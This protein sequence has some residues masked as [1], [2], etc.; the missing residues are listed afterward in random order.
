MGS[1][2]DAGRHRRR[3]RAVVGA[4]ASLALAAPAGAAGPIVKTTGGLLEGIVVGGITGFRGVPLGE[5]PIGPL[6]WT[7][8]RPARSWTGVRKADSYAAPCMQAKSPLVGGAAPS[9]DCL[10]L[11][12]WTK[13]L[14]PKTPQPVMVVI[15]GGGFTAGSASPP[16]TD[17]AGL[18]KKDV[19]VVALP[20]RVGTL[21]FLAHPELTRESP[22]HASGNYAISDLILGLKWVKANARRFG[23]DPNNVT[24]LGCSAGGYMSSS[25]V[26]SPPAAGL[27][28]R[29]IPESGAAAFSRNAL[30]PGMAGLAQNERIGLA[31]Q[32]QLGARSLAEMRALPAERIIAAQAQ[33]G[34]GDISTMALPS[35]DGYFL[36][37]DAAEAFR[38][39][40]Y[41][42]VDML[43][44]WTSNE[45][46]IFKPLWER[47]DT[48]DKFRKLVPVIAPGQGELLTSIYPMAT[49]EQAK[50]SAITFVGDNA[51]GY[52]NWRL[53]H[54]MVRAGQKTWVYHF[55]RRSSS[56]TF[57]A[58]AAG[59][60][61]AMLRGLH[62]G[63]D[64]YS[65]ASVAPGMFFAAPSNSDYLLSDTLSSYWV[66]FAR[67][68]DPNGP[69]L[70]QWP[71]YDAAPSGKVLIIDDG[72]SVGEIPSEHRMEVLDRIFSA[73]RNGAPGK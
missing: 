66:N 46:A 9:E 73:Q 12:V 14:T 49:D 44:G 54:E 69:G 56:P 6:R 72:V 18:A 65:T 16:Q 21:G 26:I 2:A 52:H 5:P 43:T 47:I 63:N 61:D 60:P 30:N 70:P 39:G 41:N 28:E 27:F 42:R 68:G 53:T 35:V 31:I 51:F 58:M 29:A 48:A 15:Y 7:E 17:G 23:G 3:G 33:G 64:A 36:P 8:A 25:L 11:N 10:Y 50:V 1:I 13:T 55:Q 24:V 34:A 37:L 38:T 59:V 71:R 67:S 57:K 19:V 62:C 4:I 20:Y 45:G 32:R 22:H 40:R